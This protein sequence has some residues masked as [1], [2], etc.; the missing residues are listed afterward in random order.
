MRT[1]L[2][3]SLSV[4]ALLASTAAPADPWKDEGGK[5]R[6]RFD[7]SRP[8][9]DPYARDRGE[10]KEEF[11]AQGCKVKREWKKGEYKEEVKC[12]DRH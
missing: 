5:D 8:Y 7:Y 4:A 9:A 12:D 6:W 10:Y 11:Y 2:Y 1:T 3:A